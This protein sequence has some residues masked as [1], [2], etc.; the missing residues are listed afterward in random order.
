[1]LRSICGTN[2]RILRNARKEST[3]TEEEPSM[4]PPDPGETG[5]VDDET[6]TETSETETSEDDEETAD[7]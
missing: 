4:P 2:L 7:A 1:M 6:Q 3:L 5:K